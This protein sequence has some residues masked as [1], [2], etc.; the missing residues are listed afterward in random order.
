MNFSRDWSAYRA[1]FGDVVSE[2]W[3][4]NDRISEQTQSAD[5][6][7]LLRLE[8]T[9]G[10]V[11]TARYSTFKLSNAAEKFRLTADGYSGNAGKLL[12]Y[13]AA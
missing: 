7:L 12:T 9:N 11:M 5:S 2:F 6:E 10:V 8:K 13:A 3:L 1:G 4:G